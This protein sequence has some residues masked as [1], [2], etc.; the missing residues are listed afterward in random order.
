VLSEKDDGTAKLEYNDKDSDI[1]WSDSQATDEIDR[2][3]SIT[4]VVT[5]GDYSGILLNIQDRARPEAIKTVDLDNVLVELG[6]DKLY[7]NNEGDDKDYKSSF[8]FLDQYG[9]E[10]KAKDAGAF[11]KA[12]A[13]K[14]IAGANYADYA[15]KVRA[16]YKGNNN[17]FSITPKGGA[18]TKLVKDAEII[19]DYSDFVEASKT[20]TPYYEIK[21]VG[22]V[23]NAQSGN[24]LKFDIVKSKEG[25]LETIDPKYDT[26][27]VSSARNVDL[28]IVDITAVRNFNID[29]VKKFYIDTKA[30]EH[31]TFALATVAGV[32]TGAVTAVI[33]ADEFDAI[34]SDYKHEVK[35]KGTY[36]GKDVTVPKGYLSFSSGKLKFD[37]NG[38]LVSTSP[39][40][41]KWSDFYDVT[42][43]NYLRKDASDTVTVKIYKETDKRNLLDTTSK[44]IA[45]SDAK[46]KETTIEGKDTWAVAPNI[47]AI[48]FAAVQANKDDK[49]SFKVF[50]Q[51]GVDITKSMEAD[52]KISYKISSIEPNEDGYADNN[53]TVENNDMATVKV[54]KGAER[55]DTFVLIIKAGDVSK[56]VKVTV[57]ADKM[58][59]IT[60]T[61][62]NYLNK[63]I[64]EPT[65]TA[66]EK[67][68][69]DG[70]N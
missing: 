12:A 44:K 1:K 61:E 34:G 37:G 26:Q 51:Y 56:E 14:D 62:N 13:T 7:L 4:S 63:L 21:A 55:G 35:V 65:G 17:L 43:A 2:L 53:F 31:D 8:V 58:A 38:K 57:K 42:T 52:G 11:F 45:L 16:T 69:L 30:N 9:R 10:M 67:Q 41:I 59:N 3:V 6:S 33:P 27:S 49:Y 18:E 54:S 48:D 20:D 68:R 64:G 19:L 50:D 25:F 40:A 70:L 60:G 28:A 32:T 66:L 24:S 29:D 36:N 47:T 46:P 39:N 22:D 15:F 5:G 23:G